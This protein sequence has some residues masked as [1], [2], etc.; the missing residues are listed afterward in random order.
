VAVASAIY[1]AP[2]RARDRDAPRFA[3]A[4]HGVES[5]LVGIGDAHGE[6]ADRMLRRFAE[7]P[8]GTLVWSRTGEARYALGC[9]DGPWRYDDSRAARAVGIRHVRPA[10]WLPR[11]FGPDEV[12]VAV[13]ETFARGGRNLQRIHSDLAERQSAAL[14]AD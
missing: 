14:W 9:I 12:P 6:K 1:R 8:D 4:E 13:A 11:A 7:L 5:G 3:G 2:M 10:R